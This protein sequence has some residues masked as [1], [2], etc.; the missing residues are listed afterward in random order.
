MGGQLAPKAPVTPTGK[1]AAPAGP[2][3]YL[4]LVADPATIDYSGWARYADTK[5][6]QRAAQRRAPSSPIVVDEDEP[7]GSTGSNDTLD[8]AQTVDGFGTGRRQNARLTILGTSSPP[9]VVAE[10]VD[11]TVEDDGSIP[12]VV[13]RASV[14]NETGSPRLPQSAMDHMAAPGVGQR[15]LRLLCR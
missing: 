3:P 14:S 11:A 7:A 1:G 5:G 2:N 13:R 6:E 10:P 8:T 4:A 15:G 9:A 12:L